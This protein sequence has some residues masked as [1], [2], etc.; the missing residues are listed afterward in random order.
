MDKRTARKLLTEERERL[1]QIMSALQEETAGVTGEG[2]TFSEGS[3]ADEHPAD[4]GS[5]TFEL[6]KDMSIRNNV[7]AELADVERA[8]HRLDEGTFG[9][10][11]ACGRKIPEQRLQAIPAARF[12]IK[13]QASAEREAKI[14]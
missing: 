11:E 12:C 13:D 5:E 14:A 10:C 8:F 1:Q 9:T 6:E 4:V 3:L 2:E 7:E